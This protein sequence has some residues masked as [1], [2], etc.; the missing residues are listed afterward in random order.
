MNVQDKVSKP[1]PQPTRWSAPFWEA[2][3]EG[4]LVIQKCRS[5]GNAVFYPRLACPHCFSEDLDWVEASGR[6]RVYSYT[7]VLNN[8]PTPFIVD[9]PYVVAIIELE[10]GVRLL[11]N[12]VEA[13]TDELRCEMPVEVTFEKVGDGE[14]FSLPKFRP[15]RGG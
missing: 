8:P 3:R 10:E 6:G 15:R 5:C 7:L 9:I 13:D 1:L 12:I 11:S 4:R 14:E 2:A